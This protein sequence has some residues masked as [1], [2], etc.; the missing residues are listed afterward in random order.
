MCKTGFEETNQHNPPLIKNIQKNI[1]DGGY[2][3]KEWKETMKSEFNLEIEITQITDIANGKSPRL[4]ESAKEPLLG[5]T[6]TDD[7]PKTMKEL[8]GQ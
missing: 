3:G 7:S 4:D 8:R 5:S 6:K 1:C 2:D